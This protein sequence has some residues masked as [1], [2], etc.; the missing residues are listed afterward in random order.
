MCGDIPAN[1][2]IPVVSHVRKLAAAM[3]GTHDLF[4]QFSHDAERAERAGVLAWRLGLN[5]LHRNRDYIEL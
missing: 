1:Y 4:V 3:L 2:R 5:I